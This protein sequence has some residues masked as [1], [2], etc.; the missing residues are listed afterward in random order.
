VTEMTDG[1]AGADDGPTGLDISQRYSRSD[2]RMPSNVNR[3]R[4]LYK[5]EQ[6]HLI[7]EMGNKKCTHMSS[8]SRLSSDSL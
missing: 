4:D 3:F 1:C 5:V 6:R 2:P 7:L 8:D